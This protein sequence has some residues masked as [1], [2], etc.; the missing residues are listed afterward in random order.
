MR[1]VRNLRI[2]YAVLYWNQG[3]AHELFWKTTKEDALDYIDDI[4]L[5]SRFKKRFKQTSN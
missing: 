4:K 5:I 3:L 2:T 1:L